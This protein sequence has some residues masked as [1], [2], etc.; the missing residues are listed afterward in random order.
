MGFSL[1]PCSNPSQASCVCAADVFCCMDW[2]QTC[3]DY[4]DGSTGHCG[5]SGTCGP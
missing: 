3:A 5:S 4:Y 1:G 2:D